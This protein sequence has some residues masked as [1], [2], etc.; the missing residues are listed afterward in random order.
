MEEQAF[1][2]RLSPLP[3]AVMISHL[4][5]WWLYNHYTPDGGICQG[6]NSHCPAAPGGQCAAQ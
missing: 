3:C 1:A 5:V 2:P 4:P 6:R